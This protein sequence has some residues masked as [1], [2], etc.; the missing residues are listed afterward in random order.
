MRGGKLFQFFKFLFRHRQG[1]VCQ[2]IQKVHHL[3]SGFG[4]FGGNG[5][6][7]VIMKTQQLRQL[8]TQAQ[9]LFH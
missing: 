5:T 4:H 6:L 1:F 2:I 9:D 8:V 3:L 7:G